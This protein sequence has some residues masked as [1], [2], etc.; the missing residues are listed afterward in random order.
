[1]DIQQEEYDSR[2]AEVFDLMEE[3]ENATKTHYQHQDTRMVYVLARRLVLK[4]EELKAMDVKIHLIKGKP[5]S[6]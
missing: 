4:Q 3:F 2:V 6:K 5:L 1:M